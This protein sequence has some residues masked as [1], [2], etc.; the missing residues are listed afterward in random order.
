MR[1]IGEVDVARCS[2]ESGLTVGS[3]EDESGLPHSLPPRVEDTQME[4]FSG[5][6]G[7]AERQEE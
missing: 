2:V 3:R 6:Y 7:R 1:C 4:Q 5:I